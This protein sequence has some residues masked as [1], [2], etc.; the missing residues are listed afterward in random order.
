MVKRAFDFCGAVFLLVVLSPLLAV[1]A[2]IVR[3]TR[4][5]PVLAG[6]TIPGLFDRP[7]EPAQA[8]SI[9]LFLADGL[10]GPFMIEVDWIDACAGSFP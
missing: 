6:E 10:D 4:G 5:A 1:A 7:F 2:L 8:T 9:G 3:L